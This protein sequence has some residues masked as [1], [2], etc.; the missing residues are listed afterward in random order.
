MRN[1]LLS[2]GGSYSVRKQGDGAVLPIPLL[3]I[4]SACIAQ[5]FVAHAQPPDSYISALKEK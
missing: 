4:L 1:Y 3:V 5:L 2:K